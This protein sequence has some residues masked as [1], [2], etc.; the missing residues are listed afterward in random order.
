MKRER[1]LNINL[2]DKMRKEIF[3][4]VKSW[5]IVPWALGLALAVS[6]LRAQTPAGAV[7]LHNQNAGAPVQTEYIDFGSSSSV[8]GR[9][10]WSTWTPPTGSYQGHP[11]GYSTAGVV[12][13]KDIFIYTDQSVSTTFNT[14]WEL[15]FQ[16]VPGVP[17]PDLTI[18]AGLWIQGGGFPDWLGT[19]YNRVSDDADGLLPRARIW[20]TYGMPWPTF[21]VSAYS[22][23][24]GND[25]AAF[26][27]LQRV[28]ATEANCKT[29]TPYTT[30]Q[31]ITNPQYE[32]QVVKFGY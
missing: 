23:S 22:S 17:T 16:P 26:M 28:P 8:P 25:G 24:A 10:V 12:R 32:I 15:S 11:A 3:D 18:W 31:T 27:R 30:L 7:Y 6:P 13:Y 21:R 20:M 9:S 14:C 5:R 2:K 19:Y 4:S 1:N 29:S